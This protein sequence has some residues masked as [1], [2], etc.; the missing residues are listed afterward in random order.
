MSGEIHNTYWQ[1]IL[2][3]KVFPCSELAE[4]KSSCFISLASGG[5]LLSLCS[6]FGF[7]LFDFQVEVLTVCENGGGGG[8]HRTT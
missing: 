6:L 2:G 5:C 7:L 4:T 3:F 1:S 8:V